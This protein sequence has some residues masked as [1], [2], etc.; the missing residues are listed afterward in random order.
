MRKNGL[1]RIEP[2]RDAEEGWRKLTQDVFSML[3]AG[4]VSRSM[5]GKLAESKHFMGGIPMY[6]QLC[7]QSA[8][9]GYTGFVL[10]KMK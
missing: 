4:Q 3:L 7:Q 10:S 5:D 9:N 2:T 6:G 8:E 1:S